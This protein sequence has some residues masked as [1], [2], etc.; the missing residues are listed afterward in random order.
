MSNL[1]VATEVAD[2]EEEAQKLRSRYLRAEI[3]AAACKPV[4]HLL[5]SSLFWL[6][7]GSILAIAASIKLHNAAFLDGADWLTFGRVRPA[8]LTTMSYGWSTMACIGVGLWIMSRLCRSPLRHTGWLHLSAILFNLGNAVGVWGIMAGRS[9]GIEWLEYPKEA[10]VLIVAAFIP[11]VLAFVDMARRRLPGHI[12]VSQWYLMAAVFWFPWLYLTVQVLMIWSPVAAPAQPPM[13]WWYGH[14]V[15]GLWF[16]PVCLAAA[17]YLIPKV[18]GKPIH[19]YYLSIVGF[20][21]LAFFYAWNGMHHLVGGPYPAWMIGLS[22]VASF[23]MVIP[24]IAVAVNHHFTAFKDIGLVRSSPTFRFVVFG[25]F[26]YTAVS[27][28]GTSM[29]FRD[30]SKITHFTHYTIG[31]SHLG[32]YAFVTM[33]LFG[34]IYYMMPRL[35]GREWPS[36]WLIRIHFWFCGLGVLWYV[37]ALS[38]G[39]FLQG[40]WMLDD[41]IPFMDIVK[42]MLPYLEQRT[43]AGKAMTIGHVA[44]VISFIWLLLRKPATDSEPTLLAKNPRPEPVNL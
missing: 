24:V 3:D 16:T 5:A 2:Q 33:I 36:V 15:L 26:S 7:L 13:N 39:G 32:M 18:I 31:H 9:T 12:Y 30:L 28:Q 44:F 22:I 20:W 11:V 17:Y 8:H 6:M 41:S 40:R 37:M 23:M 25:T 4:I 1:S 35:T 21:S 19:S 14:N 10:G 42:W 29:A 27:L 34:A 38:I 43:W